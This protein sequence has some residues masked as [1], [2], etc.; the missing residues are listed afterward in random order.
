MRKKT[1]GKDKKT[2]LK[3]L[4]DELF[5]DSG[6]VDTILNCSSLDRKEIAR[7]PMRVRILIS[8]LLGRASLESVNAELKAN[9]CPEL[10]ARSFLEA[11]LIYAFS[12]G[13]GLGEW[14]ALQQDCEDVRRKLAPS[15]YFN[16]GTIT[17]G[18]LE[19]YVLDNSD[20]EQDI[21]RTR[22]L[23][24]HMSSELKSL[25]PGEAPLH[26]FLE[27]NLAAFSPAREK[28]R[29]YFCKYLYYYLLV[30]IE[31]YLSSRRS[32]NGL[33]LNL[34]Q[35]CMLIKI[36]SHLERHK[37]DN[38]AMIWEQLRR[39]SISLGGIFDNF[40]Y[41]FFDFVTTEWLDLL[42]ED[43]DEDSSLIPD[44]IKR[45]Y[46]RTIGRKED[47]ELNGAALD[48]AFA[49]AQEQRAEELDSSVS[50]ERCGEAAMRRYLR[51]EVDM[52]RTTL[53]CMLLFCSSAAVLPPE[54]L[55]NEQRVQEIL[56]NCGYPGLKSGDAFD[57][58]VRDAVNCRNME[59]LWS[60]VR[61][62]V[63]ASVKAGEN[64]FLY[65]SYRHS[66]SNRKQLERILGS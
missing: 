40:N 28:T 34:E 1:S 8:A 48:S 4:P 35:L 22:T 26:D 36:S 9:G 38:E 6:T 49:L 45:K 17:F 54:Q 18:E 33:E 10:Y 15:A 30:K 31:L 52:D 23:T 65:R 24:Q 12:H 13:M 7:A 39:S 42:D 50:G 16:S 66:V 46:L 11:T 44:S 58:F 59:A 32:G 51:G 14:L 29:Y 21:A 19:R 62:N 60:V 43:Y 41:F 61:G 27:R 56:V 3:E 63:S 57:D 25:L 20:T 37:S 2:D 53:L 5:S 64:S 55:L 47:A